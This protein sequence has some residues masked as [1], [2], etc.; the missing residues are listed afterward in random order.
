MTVKRLMVL[1]ALVLL[2]LACANGNNCDRRGAH[3]DIKE[4]GRIVHQ[5]CTSKPG[6]TGLHWYAS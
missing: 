3:R 6:D 2:G 4:N 5:T 1:A